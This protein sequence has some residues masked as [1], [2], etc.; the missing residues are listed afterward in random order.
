VSVEPE[1]KLEDLEKAL[2]EVLE[3]RNRLWAELNERQVDQR[4]LEH[5]RNEL[6]TVR[7][8]T[9]WKLTVLLKRLR[10]VVGKGLHRLRTR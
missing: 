9:M 8:S 10:H 6:K 3:E 4:E 7:D 5:L 1:K 2:E